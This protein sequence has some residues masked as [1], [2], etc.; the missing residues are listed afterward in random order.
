ML[1]EFQAEG[2]GFTSRCRMGNED[3][4]C[5]R[6][7]KPIAL[8]GQLDSGASVS[9]SEGGQDQ[10]SIVRERLPPTGGQPHPFDATGGT[11]DD[12]LLAS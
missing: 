10:K 3:V 2:F 8:L 6:S 12:R 9:G 7:H 11:N 1:Q 5:E 4:L